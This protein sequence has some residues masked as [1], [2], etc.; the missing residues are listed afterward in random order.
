MEKQ[1]NS[2]PSWEAM[3]IEEVGHVGEVLQGDDKVS[4]VGTTL[5]GPSAESF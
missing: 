1:P 4:P 3:E 2:T 5:R